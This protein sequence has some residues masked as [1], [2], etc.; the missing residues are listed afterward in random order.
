MV[1][2]LY[3]FCLI[4]FVSL[5]M[6]VSHILVCKQQIQTVS[7]AIVK[8]KMQNLNYARSVLQCDHIG[9]KVKRPSL[10]T[11][12]VAHCQVVSTE[13]RNFG[14]LILTFEVMCYPK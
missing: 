8:P 1:Q 2:N 10:K 4:Q 13:N 6:V 12:S 7:A 11:W 9:V 14:K 3:S 5:I